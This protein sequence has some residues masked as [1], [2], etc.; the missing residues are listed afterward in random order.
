MKKLFFFLY[1]SIALGF[2]SVQAQTAEA[3]QLLL[4]VE[5][6]A[7]LKQILQDMKTGYEVLTKGYATIKSIS[8][9]NF[10][11]HESFLNGLLEVSPSVRKYKKLQG[12]IDCQLRIVKEYKSAY[13]NFKESRQFDPGELE[14]ISKVYSNLFKQSLK[15]LDALALVITSGKLRMSDE[16]RLNTIDQICSDLQD[17]LSFLRHFNN[18]NKIL[19]L[20]R[21]REKKEVRATKDLYGLNH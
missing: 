19:A 1:C 14:Y 3:Q 6:L 17:R 13:R 20:Q 12:I 16:E 10:N 8:E 7:Q 5:K 21:A 2:S 4:N 11:L 15:N 18:Q 9:G